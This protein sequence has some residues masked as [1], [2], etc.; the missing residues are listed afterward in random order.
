M[1]SPGARVPP[2]LAQALGCAPA[3]LG[4]RALALV[5]DLLL[6]G[7]AAS[8]ILTRLVLPQEIPDA[9]D[10]FNHQLQL[11]LASQETASGKSA[12]Y[13]DPT[14]EFVNLL[15]ISVQTIFLT[16]FGY[17]AGCELFGKGASLG[18][19]IFRL[20]VAQWGTGEPPRPL[21]ILIRAMAK[22]ASLVSCLSLIHI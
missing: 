9:A 22:T 7:I 19:R 15:E 11:V 3:P 13:P 6:A 18:K 14:P 20:R 2:L 10:V 8:L 12:P 1:T 21:E 17:F 4:W 16:L 5:L